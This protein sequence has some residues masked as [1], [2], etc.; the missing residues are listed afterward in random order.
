ML[1]L[2]DPEALR[3]GLHPRFA[4]IVENSNS[5]D[6]L[7]DL[8]DLVLGRKAEGIEEAYAFG[9][10]DQEELE[11]WEGDA[12]ALAHAISILSART[13]RYRRP[14][15]VLA[16]AVEAAAQRYKDV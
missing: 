9:A 2:E 6:E 11:R 8:L 10:I 1:K 15:F 14:D 12:N 7:I 13:E 3:K 5:F 16:E 4:V